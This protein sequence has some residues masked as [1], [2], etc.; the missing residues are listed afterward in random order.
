M[1]VIPDLLISDMHQRIG[2]DFVCD[3]YEVIE[4]NDPPVAFYVRPQ[5]THGGANPVYF[6]ITDERPC[7]SEVAR[8]AKALRPDALIVN[9]KLDEYGDDFTTAYYTARN[10]VQSNGVEDW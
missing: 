9:V 8:F 2:L 6:Y 3:G 10:L 4:A 1:D 5:F 7:I